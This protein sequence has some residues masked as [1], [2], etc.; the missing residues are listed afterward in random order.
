MMFVFLPRPHPG[1]TSLDSQAPGDSEVHSGLGTSE[2]RCLSVFWGLQ[3][4]FCLSLQESWVET[5][6]PS[7]DPRPCESVAPSG[8]GLVSA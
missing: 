3:G 7:P 1:V 5:Q 8:P 4:T 6:S 2:A